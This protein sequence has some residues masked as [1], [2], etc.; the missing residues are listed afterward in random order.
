MTRNP[1]QKQVSSSV[2]LQCNHYH[3]ILRNKQPQLDRNMKLTAVSQY[4]LH[5]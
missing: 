2:T 1:F 5:L 3:L 4:E